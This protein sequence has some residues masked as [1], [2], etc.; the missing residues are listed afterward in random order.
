MDERGGGV[1]A[2]GG[3]LEGELAG[4][5]SVVAF[6]EPNCFGGSEGSGVM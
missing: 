5:E 2:A 1:E 6:G 4:V 3:L